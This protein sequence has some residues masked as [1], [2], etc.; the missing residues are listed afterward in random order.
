MC[1]SVVTASNTKQ[2]TQILNAGSCSLP[3]DTNKKIWEQLLKQV[4]TKNM[5]NKIWKTK[6]T[7]MTK[8]KKGNNLPLSLLPLSLCPEDPRSA[9]DDLQ[10][11][12]PS[13]P[14]RVHEAWQSWTV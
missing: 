5:E 9:G 4:E 10:P 2:D 11:V 13:R 12:A 3:K 6:R 1:F 14:V 8:T 7:Q